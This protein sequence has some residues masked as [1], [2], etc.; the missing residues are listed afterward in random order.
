MKL[1]KTNTIA[2]LAIVVTALVTIGIAIYNSTL[3]D[4]V[5]DFQISVDPMGGS[6]PQ[7]SVTQM[8]ITVKGIHE[9]NFVVSLSSSGSPTGVVVNPNPPSNKPIPFYTSNVIITVTSTVPEGDYPIVIK[10]TGADGKEHTCTYILTVKPPNT[11][12]VNIAPEGPLALNVG[13]SQTF[14]A[15]SHGGSGVIHYQWYLDGSAVSGSTSSTY[16]FGGSAGRYS[17]TCKVTDSASVPVTSGASNA[18]SV[19]VNSATVAPTVVVSP[20]SWIMDVGQS[21]SFSATASDGSGSYSSYQWYVGGVAQSG[22]TTSTF[23]YN[24]GSVGSS[25]ITVTVTDSLG[26]TSVQ[27]SAASVAVAALPT[28][29]IAP[30]GSLSMIAGQSQAFTAT[31]SGGSGVIHYQWYLDGS[32]VGSDSS[33][34]SYT[35]AGASHSVTCKVTDTASTPVTSAASNAVTITVTTVTISFPIGGSSASQIVTA[36]G[37]SQ[38]IPSGQVIW[39]IVYVPSIALYYPMPIAAVVQSS[40]AW[41][42]QVTVGGPTD[43]GLQFDIIMVLANQAGQASLV[44]YNQDSERN[45]PGNYPGIPQLPAGLIECSKVTVTRLPWIT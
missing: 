19:K 41:Q 20:G 12:A 18:V 23:S 10:G 16:S 32:P 26:V 45:H 34:Y 40:G 15:T 36:Q 11:L 25:P 42:T 8:T 43:T 14:T 29:T 44:A 2:I 35:A 28:V 33:S 39:A 38:N 24:A 17:V 30:V 5:A 31:P 1:T 6:I 21:K 9:Y 7:G 3:I 22:A 4:H 37:T 13:Q 27:S